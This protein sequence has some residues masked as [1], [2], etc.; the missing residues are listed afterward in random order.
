MRSDGVD[1]AAEERRDLSQA[2]V[3][4]A[5]FAD[6]GFIGTRLNERFMISLLGKSRGFFRGIFYG[7]LEF[8]VHGPPVDQ[9]DRSYLPG[10]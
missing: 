6:P 8:A 5:Y 7:F 10:R 4:A 9:E 3:F 2:P 1:G